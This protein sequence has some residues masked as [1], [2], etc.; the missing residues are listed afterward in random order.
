MPIPDFL[1]SLG[2]S[3][4][5]RGIDLSTGIKL[6]TGIF[7]NLYL[8]IAGAA[9]SA[10]YYFFDALNGPQTNYLLPRIIAFISRSLDSIIDIA[11]Y[12]TPALA[13]SITQFLDC[14]GHY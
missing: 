11:H 14:V 9:L 8:V 7:N 13:Q 10:T 4:K 6:V 1:L 2:G 3:L 12:C 5:N